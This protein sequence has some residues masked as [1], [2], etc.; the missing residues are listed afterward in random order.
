MKKNIH[1]E[2]FRGTFY[3]ISKYLVK[4]YE[5]LIFVRLLIFDCEY[6]MNLHHFS[7]TIFFGNFAKHVLKNYKLQESNECKNFRK[8]HPAKF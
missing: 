2:D 7:S 3:V 1:Q 8:E 6:V 4:D 5:C